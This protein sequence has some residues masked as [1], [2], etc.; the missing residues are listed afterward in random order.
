MNTLDTVLKRLKDV[1]MPDEK[2]HPTEY[3][4]AVD[5]MSD[6]AVDVAC[7]MDSVIK[8][9]IELIENSKANP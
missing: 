6:N 5:F 9:L 7:G 4:N 2:T 8:E 3:W 1:A